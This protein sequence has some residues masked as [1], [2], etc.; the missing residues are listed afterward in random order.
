M[1]DHFFSTILIAAL[2]LWTSPLLCGSRGEHHDPTDYDVIVFGATPADLAAA[3]AAK[4]AGAQ[5]V[6]L[7]EPTAHVGGMASPGGIGLRDCTLNEV[8]SNNATQYQWA[9]RNA[10]FYG[11]DDPVWQP[12]GWVGEQTFLDMLK[13]SDVELRL[14]TTFVE[15]SDG[16]DTTVDSNDGMRRITGIKLESGESVGCKYVIDAS[17]EGELMIS[18]GHVTYTFGRESQQQ[19]N[20]SFAGVTNHS[21]GQFQYPVNP[22]QSDNVTLLKWIQDRPDPRERIGAADDNV[23]A[24]TFRPCLSKDKNNMVPFAPPPGYDPADFELQRRYL[25]AELAAGKDPTRPWSNVSYDASYPSS[26]ARKYNA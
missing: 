14:N 7:L 11:V 5:K 21:A 8:R 17:Y 22:Y 2:L 18:T 9:M 23:M 13:E 12:D 20:E 19:Y 1:S 26:K 15:G 3:L 10:K 16:V 24:Y 6:L 4:A 25:V